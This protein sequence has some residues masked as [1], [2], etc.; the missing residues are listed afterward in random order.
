MKTIAIMFRLKI[1]ITQVLHLC[2]RVTVTPNDMA[3][4]AISVAIVSK[5]LP[6]ALFRAK[7]YRT[8]LQSL[9]NAHLWSNTP[10]KG[11]DYVFNV[12]S[13][14]QPFLNSTASIG[15]RNQ[16]Q[17]P[18]NI[19]VFVGS[20]WSIAFQEAKKPNMKDFEIE[21]EEKKAIH[22]E[23]N[24]FIEIAVPTSRQPQETAH[25]THE[26]LG[27]QVKLF[28]ICVDKNWQFEILR[29]DKYLSV[30]LNQL[31]SMD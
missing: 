12:H 15:A 30:A 31:M 4:A 10:Q 2:T 29:R 26:V 3:L 16:F 22:G 13:F 23:N 1:I 19:P 11:D 24:F 20:L 17:K 9:G 5:P 21:L 25:H 14:D 27:D 28:E 6:T 7:S 18:I 8:Q